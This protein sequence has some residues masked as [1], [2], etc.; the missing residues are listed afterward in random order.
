[1]KNKYPIYIP[2]K[3]R[4]E[5]RLTVKALDNIGAEYKIVVEPSE[6]DKYAS[7]ISP[8]KILVLPDDNMLLIGSRNWIHQHS[9]QAGDIRHWQLDDNIRC[10]YRLNN[11][12]KYRVADTTIFRCAEDFSDRYENVVISGFN[13]ELLVPRIQKVPPYYLNTRVYSMS[14]IRNDIKHKWRSIYNDDTDICLN[15]LKD[16]DCTIL[17]NAFLCDKAATM[18]MKGG[19]TNELY[20]IEDGRLK[21]ALA[22]QKLHP[23]V[24]TVTH[25]FNRVQHQVNYS[26]FKKNKLIPKHPVSHLPIIDEYGMELHYI[27]TDVQ[28]Q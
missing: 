23:D 3:G 18:T 16:G 17:F 9:L 20:L 4:H 11:N 19:N 26:Q 5:S 21:M 10:F 24:C 25:K 12:L 1:M 22:L 7:V 28:T 6:Y 15:V 27:G 13:Y 2:S 8:K 14:L